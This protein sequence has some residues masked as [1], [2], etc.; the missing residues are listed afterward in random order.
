MPEKNALK[1]M[2]NAEII[3]MIDGYRQVV[4]HF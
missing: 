4:W 3:R 1:A 2:R